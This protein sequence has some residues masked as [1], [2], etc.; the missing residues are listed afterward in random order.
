MRVILWALALSAVAMQDV[1][2][3]TEV[4]F[5]IPE[6]DLYPE[7]IAYDQAT[8]DFLLSSMSQS[9]ILRI[10]ADGSYEDFLPEGGSLVRGSGTIGMKVDAERRRLWVCVGRYFLFGGEQVAAP[11]TGVIVFDLDDGSVINSWMVE[12]PSPAYIFNDIALTSDG[13]AFVTTTMFGSIYRLSPDSDEMELVL[14]SP[15]S[16]NN[17]IT[18]D[19]DER[20]LFFTLDRL[21]RRLDLRSGAVAPVTVPDSAEVGTDGL[22]FVD[23]ALV[24]VKPR[25]LQISRLVLDRTL[26]A[27]DSVEV[28]AEGHP[29]FA[30]PTTGV[31]V[32]DDLV[33]VATSFADLPRDPGRVNQHPAVL[34]HRVA[35]GSG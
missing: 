20:F 9:R 7:S 31:I 33:F 28:L 25:A 30:Y 26:Q 27:V 10:H 23:G 17:G 11:E 35:L 1:A 21:I 6:H 15:G 22:Y 32:G 13:A 14:E 5:T 34:I 19:P 8:G 16:H 3:Q 12:Q 4:L 24:V 29:D 18:L 2:A